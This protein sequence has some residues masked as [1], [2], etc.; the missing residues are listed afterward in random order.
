MPIFVMAAPSMDLR[1]A[2]RMALSSA[3]FRPNSCLFA[4][5]RACHCLFRAMRKPIGLTFCPR[6]GSSFYS[7]VNTTVR[8]LSFFWIGLALPR[9]PHQ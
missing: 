3:W 7:F 4:N 5:Q 2:P 6:V 9:A 1:T 8:W